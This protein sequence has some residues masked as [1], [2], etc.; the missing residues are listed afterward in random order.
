ML[1]VIYLIFYPCAWHLMREQAE[2]V[3]GSLLKEY[4]SMSQKQNGILDIPESSDKLISTAEENNISTDNSQ[5]P[6]T[7]S[8]T[9]V[10]NLPDPEESST[11]ALE[12]GKTASDSLESSMQ[13]L[14]SKIQNWYTSESGNPQIQQFKDV[15]AI[16]DPPRGGLH[17]T[18]SNKHVPIKIYRHLFKVTWY[19]LF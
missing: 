10:G 19:I 17:P 2:D 16:V 11:H 14:G 3:M 7:K 6:E 1:V 15:V 13:D 5:N 18:V 4:V 9:S 8:G 12:N